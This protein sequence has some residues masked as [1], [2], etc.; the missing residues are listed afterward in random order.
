MKLPEKVLETINTLSGSGF[1]AYVVGGCV[2][3]VLL[4]KEPLDWDLATNARL[5]QLEELFPKAKVISDKYSVVRLDFRGRDEAWGTLEDAGNAQDIWGKPQ[6]GFHVDIATFR[7]EKGYSDSRRPDTV[8]F[9]ETIEEDL[10]RRDFTVNAIAYAPTQ[11]FV[12]SYGGQMDLEAKVIRCIGE[13]GIRFKENPIRMLRAARMVAEYDFDLAPHT[14]EAM[15]Q[16][17]RSLSKAGPDRIRTDFLRLLEAPYAGKGLALLEQ[18]HLLEAVLGFG[19]D[20]IEGEA[21][22]AFHEFIGG[23]DRSSLEMEGRLA[24]FYGSFGPDLGRQAME[25][26]HFDKKTKKRLLAQL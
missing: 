3:D 20:H 16:M 5:F 23:I 25:T 8:V 2:R 1:S 11:G 24:K 21:G 13:P 14:L 7:I 12:D 26:L 18:T 15:S 17:E 6:M 19:Q 22:I 4:G 10:K 9:V